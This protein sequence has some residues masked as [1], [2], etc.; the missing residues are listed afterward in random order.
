LPTSAARI[1]ILKTVKTSGDPTVRAKDLLKVLF[2]FVVLAGSA[3]VLSAC[4]TMRGFG[5]DVEAAGEGMQ[6]SAERVEPY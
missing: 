1:V 3:S 2:L 4:N 5:E 6:G